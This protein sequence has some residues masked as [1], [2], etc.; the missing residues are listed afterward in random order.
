MARRWGVF[1]GG[2]NLLEADKRASDSHKTNRSLPA[3]YF[4]P[5]NPDAAAQAALE[6]CGRLAGSYF[7]REVVAVRPVRR[8]LALRAR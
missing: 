7:E 5:L 4:L 3:R 6:S 1:E 8:A 2:N